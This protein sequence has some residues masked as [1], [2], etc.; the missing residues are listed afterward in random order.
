MAI[1]QAPGPQLE[2]GG[3]QGPSMCKHWEGLQL[4]GRTDWP[5]TVLSSS[6]PQRK[7][8]AYLLFRHLFLLRPSCSALLKDAGS[9]APPWG[10]WLYWSVCLARFL[11]FFS[12]SLMCTQVQE[13]V[14]NAK[15]PQ[16]LPSDGPTSQSL[17]VSIFPHIQKKSVYRQ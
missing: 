13:P 4:L 17:W 11:F 10:F 6:N 14:L 7:K 16:L 2:E 8:N 5:Q 1:L 12:F 15:K 9:C 3:S